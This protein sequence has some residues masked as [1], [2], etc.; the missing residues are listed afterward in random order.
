M[1][2][3][4]CLSDCL[5]VCLCVYQSVCLSV[6]FFLSICLS[7]CLSVCLLSVCLSNCLSVY[8]SVSLSLFLFIYPSINQSIH[9]SINQSILLWYCSI[10]RPRKKTT[11]LVIRTRTDALRWSWIPIIS[12]YCTTPL[13]TLKCPGTFLSGWLRNSLSDRL[14]LDEPK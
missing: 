11:G 6:P 1:C 8:L 10:F 4:I 2:Q 13:F 14:V 12:E 7:V 5:S 9:P 3:Y